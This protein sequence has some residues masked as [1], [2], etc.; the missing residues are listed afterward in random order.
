[1]AN[2]LDG[3]LWLLGFSSNSIILVITLDQVTVVGRP[4]II[5]TWPRTWLAM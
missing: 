2:C 4:S 3:K 5:G 1:M